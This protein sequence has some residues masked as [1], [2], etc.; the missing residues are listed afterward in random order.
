MSDRRMIFALI[1]T[2]TLLT[3]A[4]A[5]TNSYKVTSIVNNTQDQYLINP[6]GISRPIKS[7]LAENEWWLS[8][9]GT[10]FTTLYYADKSG[11]QSLAPLV[12]SIPSAGSGHG[13]PTGTAYNPAVG[14]G[15]GAE[16]FAFVS[17]DGIISNWNAGQKPTQRGSGCYQCH[18]N[19]ATTMVNNSAS[20]ASYT[21]LAIANHNN[22]ATYYAA[23]HSA[24]VE[25]YDAASF[26][27]V[28]L[29]GAFS[30]PK[31][32]TGYKPYGVQA[33]GSIIVVTFFN[34]KAGGYVDA[35]DTNGNLK[36]SL[37]QG[38]FSEPWGVSL[39]PANFG[40]FSNMLLVAN[41]S[42]GWIAAFNPKTGAFQ[43][44]LEDSTG[45][46]ITI[47]GLWGIEFGNGNPES[48]PVNTLYFTAGGNYLTGV[49][50][51]ITAN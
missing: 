18:V 41:T 21:G 3:C 35:F 37:P 6:W 27:P 1:A 26:T 22:A 31:V 4:S 39:A 11:S 30:D 23:N 12:I 15:P 16:N 34:D 19:A 42:S 51:A 48:G 49:F 7:G 44:F 43:G 29:S 10:G 32:P 50:G 36:A 14:P 5:Q 25:A 28:H 8:D 2:L 38:W 47:P 20:G 9:N 17:L 46:P 24:G 45:K 33:F 40:A 13:T